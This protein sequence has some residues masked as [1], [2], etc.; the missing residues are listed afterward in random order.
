MNVAT[1]SVI[2]RYRQGEIA[3]I[4]HVY[5]KSSVLTLYSS[6]ANHTIFYS[7]FSPLSV[8]LNY[9]CALESN[10]IFQICI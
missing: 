8:S 7:H 1:V 2:P 6:Y 9:S 4:K 5:A 10:R 3:L